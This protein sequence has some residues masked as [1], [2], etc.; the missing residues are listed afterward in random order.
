MPV[1]VVHWN[2]RR[3][4]VP[5]RVG[6]RIPL[7]RPVDN[8][9]DLLGP[10]LVARILDD[11]GLRDEGAPP[12]RLLTVG[13]ILHHAE[14]GDVVWG[15]GVNGKMVD[16]DPQLELDVRAVRG[17]LTQAHLARIGIDAPSVFGDPALL[18]GRFWPRET[19]APTTTRHVTFVPNIN[20]W[21]AHGR[22]ARAVS[23]RAPVDEVIRTIA[24]S[25]LVVATALH[26]IV[27]A[28]SLGVPARLVRPG[29]E[30]MLKYEDH[31]TGTGRPTFRVAASVDEAVALGGEP[32]PAWDPDALLAAFPADL[33][34]A[35]SR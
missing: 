15:S 28:E 29:R 33:W 3:P 14:S 9:G 20:D 17:P 7:R 19:Y 24:E 16:L 5:G 12:A 26:A 30:P 11:R 1:E 13:S 32:P 23:P 2:P 10:R 8:F 34:S 18:W 6:R 21:D 25:E 22:D 4:V 27:V 35:G 31:Y